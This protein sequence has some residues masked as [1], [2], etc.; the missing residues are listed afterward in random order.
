MEDRDLPSTASQ[1]VPT[2]GVPQELPNDVEALKALIRGL[3][4]ALEKSQRRNEQLEHRLAVL[5]KARF[6][7]RADR[8]DPKQLL[9]FAKEI[10]AEAEKP[11]PEPEPQPE[12]KAKAPS[13][14]NGHGRRP[15]PKDLPRKQVVHDLSDEEKRCPCCG[16][17]RVRISAEVSEQL[18]YEPAKLY[19][20]EHERP[21]Y[22]CP[23]CE[24]NV[25]TASKPLQPIEKGLAGPGLLAGVIT[26]KF[27]DH[28]PL[29]RQEDI[30]GRG[31]YEIP[32]ST[33]CGWLAG[34]ADLMRPLYEWMKR[35][36]LE[37][38]VI[39]TDDTPVPV[40]E[41]GRGKTREGRIW[42]YVGDQGHPYTVFDYTPTR[43]RDGP[44]RFFGKY[45][46]YIQADAYAGYDHLF[47]PKA[48]GTPVPTEVGCWAHARRKFVESQSSDPL[49]SC[50]AVAMIRL[51][52]EVEAEAKD[53]DAASRRALRQEKAVP[54]LAQIKAWLEE[55]LRDG[56]SPVLP[57]SAMGEAIGYCLNHWTALTEY[58]NDGD[59]AIDNNAAENAIR[60]IVLGRKNWLFA[61]SDNGGRTGAVLA[62]LVASCKRHGVDPF[63]YLKDVL[64]RIAA[65]P[66]SQLDQ[67]LPDRWKAAHAAPT[68]D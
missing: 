24:G 48:D 67:F 40:L 16:E 38:K 42:V 13:N 17:M 63:V 36:V 21:T 47:K 19:V 28:L 58:V 6:G 59:L 1:T 52:Y 15:L 60:P 50:T 30:L 54:R 29:Y 26:S 12:P 61:G 35:L 33:T 53:L 57:K 10:L 2:A 14:G 11:A 51:L 56:A 64:T 41:P 3:V 68:A 27:G 65:T 9:L 5:L 44:T 55:Q 45:A 62:S 7:P 20:I 31:G 23:K 4:D 18:E 34:C 39:W 46:G 22:A 37:S 8:L 32:R 66:V 49:R 43:N 25:E